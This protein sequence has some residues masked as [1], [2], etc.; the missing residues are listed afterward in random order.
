MSLPCGIGV[1]VLLLRKTIFVKSAS[2]SLFV[3]IHAN[4]TTVYLWPFSWKNDFESLHWKLQ[5]KQNPMNQR[6]PKAAGMYFFP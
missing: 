6:R 3:L 1:V 2:D 5:M 4:E